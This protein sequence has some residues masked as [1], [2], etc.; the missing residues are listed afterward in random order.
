MPPKRKFNEK[1][2]KRAIYD[3]LV[4]VGEDPNT[5]ALKETPRRVAQYF[6]EML[7]YEPGTTSTT[8]PAQYANQLVI[9]RKITG[10]SL[11]EHHLLTFKFSCVVGYLPSN[12]RVIGLSKIP[13][14]V[15]Q[16]AHALQLQEKLCWEIAHE[17]QRVT[18]ARGVGVVMVAEHLCMQCRGIHAEESD[19]ITSAVLGEFE[20]NAT[21][22]SE[23]LALSGVQ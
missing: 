23:F 20:N 3:L 21:L 4:A 8:F 12:K 17:V 18:N 9:I 19:A 5:E 16:F 14:I 1:A 22:R 15:S 10:Y 11:C 7:C 6:K 13:R 2:A